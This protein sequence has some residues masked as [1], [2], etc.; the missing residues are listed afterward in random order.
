MTT[1]DVKKAS[2]SPARTPMHPSHSLSGPPVTQK[3]PKV[4]QEPGEDANECTFHP[5]INP[6]SRSMATYLQPLHTE[7]GISFYIERKNRNLKLLREKIERDQ[8]IKCP[9]C[10]ANLYGSKHRFV[11]REDGDEFMADRLYQTGM[12]MMQRKQEKLDQYAKEQFAFQPNAEKK[13]KDKGSRSISSFLK[14]NEEDCRKRVLRQERVMLCDHD[15]LGADHHNILDKKYRPKSRRPS[16]RHP[17]EIGLELYKKGLEMYKAQAE[18]AKR[19]LTPPPLNQKTKAAN[20]KYFKKMMSRRFED[21][22]F[23]LDGLKAGCISSKNINLEA[24]NP[25]LVKVMS[26]MLYEIEDFELVLDVS[27]FVRACY[28]LFEVLGCNPESKLL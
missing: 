6:I 14:R 25:A 3:A 27:Q 10:A 5:K 24:L 17:D 8:T 4:F 16:D 12:R 18:K 13:S 21:I 20:E 11:K 19:A 26:P 15:E 2:K 23:L 22:F 9:E 7:E 28:N 1:E